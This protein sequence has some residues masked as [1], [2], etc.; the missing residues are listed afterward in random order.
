MTVGI[1]AIDFYIPQIALQIGSLAE[2]REI[3]A[4][5][6]EKGLGLKSIALADIDEDAASMAANALYQLLIN[7]SIDPKTIGRVYLGTESAL[8]SAKPTATYAIGAV[9]KKLTPK[10]GERCFKNCDVVDL[11]FACI[12]AVDALENCLDWVRVNPDKKAIVIASD[13][14]KY[15]LDSSGEYTQGAGAV[16][17]LITSNP[18][19]LEIQKTIG[20][21]MMHVGDF[22]KPR[23]KITNKDINQNGNN[24][25]INTIFNTKKEVL[26]L[27]FEEPVFDGYYSNECYQ[28]RISEALEHFKSLSNVNFLKEWNHLI[29]HLPYAFQGRRMMLDIWINWLKENN[30]LEALEKEVGLMENADYK[31]WKKA[32]SKSSLYRSFVDEKIADGEE[33]SGHIG[34]MYTASIFMSL[35]SLLSIANEK[36]QEIAG[37]KIGFLSYGSGSKS[38]IFEGIINENWKAKIAKIDVFNKIANRK[39]IDFTT[40]EKLHNSAIKE[41]IIPEKMF[42]LKSID[43]RENKIGFR[44]YN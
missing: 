5:K 43:N 29:F 39:V 27:F 7:N 4:A 32:A 16:A 41:P 3:P 2:A 33:A 26:E 23:R 21:S 40:Y 1:D 24:L 36:S 19:I 42:S 20:L 15:E 17:M 9:E 22:F 6:L 31:S 13:I 28:N 14:A 10:Y 8:D 25:S 35:I 18:N 30:Q 11:T 34:N 12:G 38:K 44:H 37:N